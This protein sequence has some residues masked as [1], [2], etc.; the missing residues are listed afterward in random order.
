MIRQPRPRKIVMRESH[1]EKELCKRAKKMGAIPYKFTS[2]GRVSVPDRLIIAPS[3][4]MAFVEVKAPGK[5]PTPMQEREHL[6]IR[7]LGHKVYILDNL[8]QIDDILN[9][10]CPS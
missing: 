5:K 6:K 2:P 1:I 7:A 10:L 3:G 8:D 4:R 9:E